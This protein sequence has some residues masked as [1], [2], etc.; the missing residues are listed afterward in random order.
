MEMLEKLNE[1][2]QYIE[3][4]LNGEIQYEKAAQ[5][6]C[7]SVYHYQRMF[8]YIAGIPLSEYI[9]NRR[10]TKAAFDL[11]AG[12]KVVDVALRYGYESPT[13]FN[14]AFRKMHYVSPSV[15]QKEGI[16][17][18][19]YP[20]I[21][22]KITIKG[23]GEMKYS[24]IKN[25]E[26]RIVGVKAPLTKNIDENFKFVPKLWEKSAEDGSIDNIVSLMNEDSNGMLGVSV[27]MDS[28]D[29][30]EY[31]IA[32][33]TDKDAPKGMHEY[34][35]PAGTWAVFPGEGPMPKSIQE[36]EKRIITEWFP[37]S[38][39]EYADAPDIELYL[40][41]D[42]TNAKFEVWIPIRKK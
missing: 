18:K 19:A 16:F 35:I 32:T 27:C 10:L 4:N 40:N 31:Y 34:I 9:R 17:L 8:S 39:Y 15:A 12:D 24:I 7:C 23:V 3:S 37:T 13:A 38:G 26:I 2:I 30:W 25:E 33:K 28:L 29:N 36:I 6:A 20:P 42:P 14:R 11:Q 21:S 1:S 41:Q 22:F 5:I